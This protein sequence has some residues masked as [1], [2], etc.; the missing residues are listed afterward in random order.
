V[1]DGPG[2]EEPILYGDGYTVPMV[3]EAI[4]RARG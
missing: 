1:I 4:E 2:L 3:R